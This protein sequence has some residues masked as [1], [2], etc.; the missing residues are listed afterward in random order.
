MSG[1][2]LVGMDRERGKYVTL[3]EFKEWV[4]INTALL[5]HWWANDFSR[6]F[7]DPYTGERIY[8]DVIYSETG[9]IH[10]IGDTEPA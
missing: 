10:K 8:W 3:D 9:L 6:F 1:K 2:T 5:R 7:F 4:K